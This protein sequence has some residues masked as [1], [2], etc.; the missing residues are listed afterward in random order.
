MEA[1]MEA[2]GRPH[3]AFSSVHVAGT[4]GKGSTAS[5]LAAIA[6]A[7]GRRVGLHTSPH[8]LH[9]SERLRLDGVPA[10]EA[11][12][13]DAV[14]RHRPVLDAMRPSF[15]EVMTA[16]SFLYFAEEAVDLAVIETGLG[17]RLDAT[18]VLHPLLSII[19]SID[20][21]HT[22][23][24]GDT[25]EAIAREKAGIIKHG[26]PVLTAAD[27]PAVLD[28]LRTIAQERQAPY[29]HLQ[30][31]LRG[32]TVALA[33]DGLRITVSTPLRDYAT[34]TVGLTG[35]HQQT[36]ALLAVRAA[37]LLFDDLGQDATPIYQGLQSVR[38]LAGLRGRLEV[39]HTHPL[40][41]AD[42]A[43]NVAGVQ[44]ALAYIDA[45][46]PHDQSRLFVLMGAMRDKDVAGIAGALANARAIVFPLALASQRALSV[47]ELTALLHTHGVATL[48]GG[49]F[50]EG[51][52]HVLRRTTPND[53]FLITGS[54]QVVAQAIQTRSS[55][56]LFQN[57]ATKI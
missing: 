38:Q 23:V 20:L 26:V 25:H 16:L 14:A 47:D 30:E 41:I 3:E 10:P 28:L 44:A 56:F 29:H 24:L 22:D 11:W 27:Q 4:N 34:M 54:H 40:I 46:G 50:L 2:M 7:A 19:T 35:L 37:E 21:D 32:L 15:F 48:Q 18:N 55:H 42:V 53:V 39:L 51:W 57:P 36:N 17:G 6:T 8:L 13:A 9:L 52:H 49:D 43:H 5:F 45:Q 12:L 31:E 1:L 33:P